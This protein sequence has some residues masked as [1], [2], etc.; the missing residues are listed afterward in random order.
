MLTWGFIGISWHL[1]FEFWMNE[2]SCNNIVSCQLVFWKEKKKK[3]QVLQWGKESSL[4]ALVFIYAIGFSETPGSG[5]ILRIIASPSF[6]FLKPILHK[7]NLSPCICLSLSPCLSP[8]KYLSMHV[9]IHMQRFGVCFTG[10]HI[11]TVA[12]HRITW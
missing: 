1:R 5:P 4:L 10:E 11:G 8:F 2:I 6:W 3:D 7:K 9:Y 12:K